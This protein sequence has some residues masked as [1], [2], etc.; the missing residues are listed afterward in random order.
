MEKM[1]FWTLWLCLI[2]IAVFL[3]QI[4]VPGFTNLFFLSSFALY[5]PWQ[6]LTA[7]FLHGDIVHLLYNL[8]A[9][10][11]FG[12]ILERTIGGMRF[13]RLFFISGILAN[14]ISFFWF[15][16]AL[17]A[18]GAIMAIIGCLAV[19]RPTMTVWAFNLPMPMFVAAIVWVGAGVLGI[20]GFGDSGVGHLAHLSGIF[21]GVIYGFYL[22]MTTVRYFENRKEE[23][24]ISEDYVRIWEDNHLRR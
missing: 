12:L 15:P 20:F 8:F 23:P 22:R 16:N 11:I 10:F 7:I 3:V 24:L 17:G 4:L 2:C 6:F 9:L 18:S 5:K 13:L 21:A 19:L 14:F 1:R